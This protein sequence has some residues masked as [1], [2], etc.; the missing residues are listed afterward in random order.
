LTTLPN[1]SEHAELR[2]MN[3]PTDLAD[4]LSPLIQHEIASIGAI[5]SATAHE[6]H[7]GYVMLFQETK[8]SKQASV[9]QMNSVLRLAG[10]REIDS[11]GVIEPALRLQTLALQKA[12]TT[13]LL[14]AMRVVE[15]LLVGR[16]A[17]ASKD[18]AGLERTKLEVASRRARKHRMILTAHIAQRKNGESSY[19][20]EL[21][22]PLSQYFASDEDRVCM[23]CLLDR[24]GAKRPLEK[25]DPYT[26]VCAACHAE[27]QSE[28]P[29]DLQSQMPRW[30]EQELHDRVIHKALSRPMKMKAVKEVHAV[31]AGLPPERPP[32]IEVT[33]KATF[34]ASLTSD[35]ARRFDYAQPASEL[36]IPVDNA[37]AEETSYTTLLFDYRSV[38]KCW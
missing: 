29:V 30:Q 8:T 21:P 32:Q 23:R 28:F 18:L 6:S 31:L 4:L 35:R 15:D 20:H 27:T 19:A 37:S 5:D 7:A 11:G 22:Y 14:G 9:K 17:E 25:Q 2:L 24:P 38:R 13:M 1:D 36:S 16:Y 3:Q 26:Y 12:S 34:A 33:R 10:Q